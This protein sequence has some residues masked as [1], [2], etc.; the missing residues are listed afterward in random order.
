[1]TILDLITLNVLPDNQYEKSESS[2][3]QIYVHHTASSPDPFGVCKWW[4]S[5]AEKVAVAFV[6]GGAPHTGGAWKDGQI[7]QCFGSQYWAWHLGLTAAECAVGGPNHKTN[8]YINQHSIGIE[9]CNWGGLQ[10]TSKGYVSY[11]GVVVPES[12]IIEYPTPFRGYK[13]FQKYTM[14]QLDSL[15]QL[16]TYL[17]TKYSIPSEYKGDRIFDICVDALCGAPGIYSHVSVRKDKSDC[18]PQP[19]LINVLKTV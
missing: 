14:S 12:Q 6:I 18:H 11:A 10:L 2:K 4:N 3:S 8:T 17:S 16:L 5:N 7:V 13:Y 1:M 15:H 19:E 9:I